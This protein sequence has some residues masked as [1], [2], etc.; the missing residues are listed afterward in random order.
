ME[1]SFY[2]NLYSA[3]SKLLYPANHAARYTN[4]L[5]KRLHLNDNY[6]FAITN[7]HI[8]A[9]LST[10]YDGS[11]A[12]WIMVGGKII[13]R[14]FINEENYKDLSKM[15]HQL[16]TEVGEFYKFE[17]KEGKVKIQKTG[18]IAVAL[19]LS[20]TLAAVL[21][22]KEWSEFEVAT[23]T[24]EYPPNIYCNVPNEVFVG[25]DIAKP[26]INGESYKSI[27]ASAC[28]NADQHPFGTKIQVKF[29]NL[30]YIPLNKNEIDGITI[31]LTDSSG[32]LLPFSS[33]TS[34][35]TL[36]F[37]KLQ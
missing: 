33:G 19:R 26:Q 1:E 3:N 21:G 6:E 9:T 32:R 2:V 23:R 11:Y 15:L 18:S 36:H 24:P 25:C 28:F 35:C 22:Y 37:R 5:P 30:Q 12:A 14:C 31:Y 29:S 4:Q 10:V 13:E 34:F 27:I 20:S 17:M 7:L 8:P 16:K